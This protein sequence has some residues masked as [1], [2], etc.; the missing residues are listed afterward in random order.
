ML[1]HIAAID[2]NNKQAISLKKLKTDFEDEQLN[3]TSIKFI[4]IFLIS[5]IV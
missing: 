3:K 5:F 2:C 1:G 4:L